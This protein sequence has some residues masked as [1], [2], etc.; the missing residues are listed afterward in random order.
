MKHHLKGHT[1]WSGE[2]QT[3][4]R[5]PLHHNVN[6]VTSRAKVRANIVYNEP[7]TFF[8]NICAITPSAMAFYVLWVITVIY[9]NL[10]S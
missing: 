7:N 4:I 8:Y 6:V 5:F 9:G 3:T 10:I 2:P 1:S